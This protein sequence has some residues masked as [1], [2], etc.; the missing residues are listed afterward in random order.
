LALALV[1]AD[2]VHVDGAHFSLAGKPFH[3]VGANLA[4]MHG[5][6]RKKSK[7]TID[8]AVSDGLTV[9][10]IWALGEGAADAT[11]WS[12]AEELFRVGPDEW[13]EPAFVQLDR[14]L[15]EAHAKNLRLI[16]TLSNHWRDYG[17]VPMYLRWAGLPV[18]GWGARDQ[19]Y[20]SPKTRGYF[21]AHLEKLLSRTN[22]LTGI[23]YLDD[24]TI[25]AWE[26]V[27][28]SS[29]DSEAGAKARREFVAE[30]A[31]L[32][33]AK[34]PNHLVSSGATIY[35]SRAERAE[36]L[37]LCK[38]PEID[39][40]DAHLYPQ[41]TDE[42]DDP[43]RLDAYIDDRAQLAEHVAHK[44][45]V[46][47][48]FGF[49][50]DP[51]GQP[52]RHGLAG[53]T[54]A[55]SARLAGQWLGAP[56]AVWFERFLRRVFSDGAGGAL[57]WIYQPGPQHEYSISTDHPDE[58][59]A[60]LHR[61]SK[62]SPSNNPL[63]SEARGD[64]PLYD[65]YRVAR[66]E[67]VEHVLDG[68]LELPVENFSLGR[69]ERV[70]VWK[71]SQYTE[72]Y[73]AGDGFFEWKFHSPDAKGQLRLRLSSE[74]P[75]ATAPPDGTSHVV[76]SID[77]QRLAEVEV[78]PDDGIGKIYSLP[79]QLTSGAHTLRLEARDH[80]VCVYGE[81]TGEGAPPAGEA[82]PIQFKWETR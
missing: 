72:A 31:R 4:V 35:T 41:T 5:H 50:V 61:W 16:I 42:V 79:V 60:V 63:L 7:E 3:F 64:A 8:A 58:V 19:F 52:A 78:I 47:G 48:E 37:A 28:E 65:V 70:G 1:M 77:G 73:G 30:M 56:R 49:L 13:L 44:P 39:Y 69:F 10:R 21:R 45:I 54:S 36:W 71:R 17:G 14:V 15:E 32:I 67:P 18:E 38:L 46:F 27:N 25:F 40:C 23:R 6:D 74:Y 33:K 76:V 75:G 43:A 57:A 68:L 2:F 9:G 55:R 51:P 22:S 24:P 81:P 82:I 62:R 34:D 59:R 53:G 26:L 29:T 20:A 80:G 66:H 12:R 11:P